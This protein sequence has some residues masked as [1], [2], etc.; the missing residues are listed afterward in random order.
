MKHINY[1]SLI[2]I[3]LG[4]A[5]LTAGA[6][7]TTSMRFGGQGDGA[8]EE[9]K[10]RSLIPSEQK[11]VKI[12]PKQRHQPADPAA[13]AAG[14]RV[15]RKAREQQKRYEAEQRKLELASKKEYE[16]GWFN[17]PSIDTIRANRK[18]RVAKRNEQI[19]AHIAQLQ[20]N[21]KR[22]RQELEKRKMRNWTTFSDMTI[23]ELIEA[24][25][26]M[27]A[28]GNKQS[29]LKFIETILPVCNDLNQVHDL[30]LEAADLFFDEGQLQKAEKMYNEFTLL[31]PGSKQVEYALYKAILCAYY[32]TLS[33]DRDQTKTHVTLELTD[34]FLKNEKMFTLH[35]ADVKRIEQECNVKLAEHELNVAKYYLKKGSP[36][37]IRAAETRIAAVREEFLPKVPMIEKNLLAYEVKLADS[38]NNPQIAQ[39][40]R[41]ELHTKFPETVYADS[42]RAT[43]RHRRQMRELAKNKPHTSVAAPDDQAVHFARRF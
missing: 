22:K 38:S 42:R 3:L 30:M 34:R 39:A 23:D 10:R 26:R 11:A 40:K 12:A 33:I 28:A 8:P 37:S 7:D 13:L 36:S 27:V 15:G 2:C 29:A 32:A 24:K 4:S 16:G 35:L 31:Y 9:P 18:E 20:P 14:G 19:N 41:A 43:E 1:L 6:S 25:T 21:Q 17:I 5:A